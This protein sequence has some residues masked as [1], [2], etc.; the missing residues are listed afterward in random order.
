MRV[1][2]SRYGE[3]IEEKTDSGLNYFSPW[4]D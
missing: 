4:S 1:K 2:T 3:A